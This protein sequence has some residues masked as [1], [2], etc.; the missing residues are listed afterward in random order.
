MLTP[1]D[2]AIRKSPSSP[3]PHGVSVRRRTATGAGGCRV[4]INYHQSAEQA[5]T[6]ANLCREAGV[7]PSRAG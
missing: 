3:V 6:V 1:A 5:E 7:K 2:Y 4:A